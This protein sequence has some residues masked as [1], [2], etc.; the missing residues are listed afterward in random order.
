MAEIS[1]TSLTQQAPSTRGDANNLR[2]VDMD[3]FLQLLIAE[4]QNQDPLSPMDNSEIL[5]QIS[6]IREIGAT[7]QLSNTLEAVLTGQNMATAAGLIGKRIQALS[8]TAEEVDG[9]VD[10]VSFENTGDGVS[11]RTLRLHVGEQEIR[12]ENIRGIVNETTE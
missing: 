6:Q 7:N 3:Q 5:Q 10:R 4:M 11:A 12:M 1:A 8:D 2:E 9:V